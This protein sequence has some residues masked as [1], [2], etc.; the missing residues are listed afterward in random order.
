[1]EMQSPQNGVDYLGM[2]TVLTVAA[3]VCLHVGIGGR[4]ETVA[5]EG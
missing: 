2:L 5:G 4:L 1:M 3:T